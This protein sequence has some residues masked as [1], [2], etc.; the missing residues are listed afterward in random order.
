MA[1]PRDGGAGNGSPYNPIL[2]LLA[3]L[4]GAA[5]DDGPADER[6]RALLNIG[7]LA[8]LRPELSDEQRDA[9][10]SALPDDLGA[11]ANAVLPTSGV[12]SP[13][14]Q[15]MPVDFGGVTVSLGEFM[16]GIQTDISDDDRTTI[17]DII[18]EQGGSTLPGPGDRGEGD[19]STVGTG[20]TVLGDPVQ[21]AG[22]DGGGAGGSGGSGGSGGGGG[23][24]WSEQDDTLPADGTA[25]QIPGGEELWHVDGKVYLAYQNPEAEGLWMIWHVENPER[26]EAIYGDDLP[27]FDREM[28]EDELKS[29]SPWYGGLSA[30]IQ[31]TS[32]DPWTQF[33]SDF[34]EA[35]KLRPWLNDPTMQAVM[36]GAYL[37]GRAPTQDELS[38]TDWWNDHTAAERA[39]LEESVTL[40]REE[41][42]RRREDQATRVG[43]ALR[44]AGVANAPDEL[45]NYIAEQSLAGQWSEQYTSEQI[46]KLSDPFAPGD[47]DEGVRDLL[48][49][50]ELDTTRQY[51]QQ[52]R[53]LMEEWL[54]PQMGRFR[55][56]DVAKWA[57][58]FRN[59]PDAQVELEDALR[60]QR[61]ALFPNYN[62]NLTYRQIVTPVENLAT[63]VWGRPVQDSSFLVDLANTMDYSEM[64]K[65]LR[66]RGRKEGVRK[67]WDD[68]LGGLGQT[69]VGERVVRSTI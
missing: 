51:E 41:L 57:G 63:Q 12:T 17:Q 38:Q 21:A 24:T 36:Q 11:F 9:F 31:N 1:V 8:V 23:N 49:D 5:Y 30:E 59:D 19:V 28:T 58:R 15:S 68:M 32:E 7:R 4:L 43:E 14:T 13:Q 6:D 45:V 2:G 34:K 18:N 60:Q 3:S 26:L 29:L 35:A 65:R 52:V 16:N 20:Q 47:L 50:Q 39:W 64:S 22:S 40:G 44:E 61:L 25:R 67:V 56:E 33:N 53:G 27:A 48:G 69:P 46:R 42:S 10:D 66:T 54:G 55:D 37:E 62:E